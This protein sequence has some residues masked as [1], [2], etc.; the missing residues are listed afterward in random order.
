MYRNQPASRSVFGK[1][2]D[3][4]FA[5]FLVGASGKSRPVGTTTAAGRGQRGMGKNSNQKP[6]R[7]SGWPRGGRFGHTPEGD[8]H[9]PPRPP[10]PPTPQNRLMGHPPLPPP[11]H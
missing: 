7:R 10:P 3:G 6:P 5:P 1:S 2:R 9:H 11:P 8:Q 4:H